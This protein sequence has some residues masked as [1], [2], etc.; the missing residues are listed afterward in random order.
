MHNK[1]MTFEQAFQQILQELRDDATR[2]R[3][4]MAQ[5]VSA[6]KPRDE[7]QLDHDEYIEDNSLGGRKYRER[8]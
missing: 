8:R 4:R 6:L 1:I 5:L 2:D 7:F 3:I